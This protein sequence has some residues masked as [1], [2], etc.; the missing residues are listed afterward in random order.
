MSEKVLFMIINNEIKFLENS[1]MDHREWY[2]SLGFD[3]NVFDQ[4]VRG[5]VLEHKIVFFKGINFNYDEEVIQMARKYSPSIRDY[6]HDP[7]L[8]VYCG[9]VVQSYGSKWEPVLRI[10]EDEISGIPV[11]TPVPLKKKKEPVETGPVIEFKNDYD[12][13][14]FRKRAIIV[15]IV[16][17]IITIIV[18]I[19]LFLEGRSLQ[20]NNFS[21]LLLAFSQVIILVFVINGYMKRL[22]YTKY[23]SL[24]ASLLIVLT[25]N[26]W[27]VIIGVL[28][29]VFSVDQ[30]YFEKIFEI[31]SKK[32][33]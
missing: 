25:L 24:L 15:T 6:C 12:N 29:F 11:Q 21:S 22:S 14:Q 13:E 3:P 19:A 17:L 2:Q 26:I 10:S 7:S 27:D 9:I 28:Y 23:L 4:I 5:Y 20:I 18:K 33:K 8:E 16:V 30:G 32:K 1:T 31:I